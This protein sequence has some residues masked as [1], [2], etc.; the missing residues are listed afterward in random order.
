MESRLNSKLM[1]F[2]VAILLLIKFALLPILSWQ[3]QVIEEISQYERKN[4]KVER[5]LANQ[6]KMFFDFVTSDKAYKTKANSYP[7]FADRSLFRLETQISF[8]MLLKQNGL[9]Q[10]QFFWQDEQ[11][12]PVF[13]NLYKAKFNVRFSGLLKDFA[14]LHS[15]LA[16][17]NK[18]YKIVN[19]RVRVK[20]QTAKSIGNASAVFSVEA[21][22]WLGDGK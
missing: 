21:Y 7:T 22:Y 5:L 4:A 6:D 10:S 3:N 20:D 13:D 17:L 19:F 11:D 9:Q 2:V 18:R 12:K 14:L 15:K 8:E 16:T 1:V